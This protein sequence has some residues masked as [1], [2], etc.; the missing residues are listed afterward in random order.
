MRAAWQESA[1]FNAWMVGI[2]IAIVIF[3]IV[4]GAAYVDPANWRP[5]A[6]FGYG[7]LSF[8]GVR[9]RGRC[10]PNPGPE[11]EPEPEPEPRTLGP[12]GPP[13]LPRRT[14]L[15]PAPQPQRH[16]H[17]LRRRRPL[18]AGTTGGPPPCARQR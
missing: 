8:F 9:A 18:G 6:P 3:V 7:G 1:R 12:P 4:V 17:P 5:F 16:Q 10:N 13:R 11:P 2:K 15:R 14:A